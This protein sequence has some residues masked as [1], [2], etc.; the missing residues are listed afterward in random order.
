[1]KSDKE[2]NKFNLLPCFFAEVTRESGVL[3]P[4]HS[5]ADKSMTTIC[6]TLQYV[7][8]FLVFPL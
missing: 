4:P 5:E 3:N 2:F 7:E 8:V 1:M 6:Y